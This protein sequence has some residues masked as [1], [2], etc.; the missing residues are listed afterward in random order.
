MSDAAAPRHA[1]TLILVRRSDD[2]PRVLMGQ[3]GSG[4]S[5]MPSKF[6]FPGGALDPSDSA[7]A[8]AAKTFGLDPAEEAR[9]AAR[10]SPE[11]R[12]LALALAAVRETWEE[13]GLALGVPAPDRAAA[14]G[15]L[16]VHEDWRSFFDAGLRPATD[17][18]R[19]IFRAVTPPTRSKRF[20]ARFFLADAETVA[21]DPDD[22]AR[23]SGE[24]S[25]LSWLTLAEARGLDLPFITEVVLAEVEARLTAPEAARPT[26]FFHHDEGRSF[27]DHL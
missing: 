1:A 3:R 17:G 26:P 27:L 6:V 7:L 10:S 24:L 20:D 21:G 8:D 19:F 23:A 11:A 18:L 15:E 4:A 12:P 22:L 16:D 5:F 14:L 25:H 13:T 2:G 9:L